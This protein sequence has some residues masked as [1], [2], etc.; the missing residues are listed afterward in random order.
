MPTGPE[1]FFEPRDVSGRRPCAWIHLKNDLCNSRSVSGTSDKYRLTVSSQ[2]GE[3]WMN[4]FICSTNTLILY[5]C[6]LFNTLVHSSFS[7]SVSSFWPLTSHYSFETFHSF[8]I[9]FIFFLW[10]LFVW[11]SLLLTK[12]D[13]LFL[14]V[15]WYFSDST[16]QSL[17][18]LAQ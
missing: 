7:S 10:I 9:I 8:F 4:T 18:L 5:I 1:A 2:T 13:F 3:F 15:L 11:W 14:F 6:I 16:I 17:P 12:T